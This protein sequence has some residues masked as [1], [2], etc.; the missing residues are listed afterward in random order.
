MSWFLKSTRNVFGNVETQ[1]LLFLSGQPWQVLSPRCWLVKSDED[2]L[3]GRLPL[4]EWICC[5]S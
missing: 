1:S 5:A 3:E 2:R 4:K